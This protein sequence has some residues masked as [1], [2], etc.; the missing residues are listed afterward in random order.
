MD[1]QDSWRQ[2]A[3]VYTPAYLPDDYKMR[4]SGVNEDTRLL[5]EFFV[6]FQRGED[7]L[8]GNFFVMQYPLGYN[9]YERH[10]GIVEEVVD[11]VQ[12]LQIIPRYN[13]PYRFYYQKDDRWFYFKEFITDTNARLSLSDLVKVASSLTRHEREPSLSVLP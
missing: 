7:W 3:V 8:Q 13:E 11:E 5:H 9:P 2:L 4:S 6:D 10:S 12:I 1:F